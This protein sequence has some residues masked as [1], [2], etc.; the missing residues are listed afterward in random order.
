MIVLAVIILLFGSG[1]I[2]K[3]SGDLGKAFPEFMR[4]I[5]DVKDIEREIKK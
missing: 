2:V 1:K 5:R 3:L 4:G